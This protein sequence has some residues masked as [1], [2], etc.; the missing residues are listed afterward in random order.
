M[1]PE[2]ISPDNVLV[3]APNANGST[4]IGADNRRTVRT[5]GARTNR[6]A[7]LLVQNVRL[8]AIGEVPQDDGAIDRR[9]C[10]HAALN[11]RVSRLFKFYVG[12]FFGVS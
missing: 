7:V 3:L 8:A 1:C 4:V 9:G 11:I 6:L 10:Q 12:I 5:E 2:P